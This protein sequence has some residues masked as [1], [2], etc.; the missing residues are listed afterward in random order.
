MPFMW[1]GLGIPWVGYNMSDNPPQPLADAMHGAWANFIKG[2]EPEHA[3]L[4]EWP[5]YDIRRRATMVFDTMTSV[6]NDPAGAVDLARDRQREPD[7]GAERARGR[8]AVGPVAR[9]LRQMLVLRSGLATTVA[10]IVAGLAMSML[11]SRLIGS[12][13]VGVSTHDVATFIAAPVI[14]IVVALLACLAPA[15]AA[16]RVDPIDVLRMD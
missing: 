16:T 13:L 2:G 5:R 1:D 10:G 3:D 15:R 11:L 8:F 6:V 9:H 4:P 7:V 14:L 12:M